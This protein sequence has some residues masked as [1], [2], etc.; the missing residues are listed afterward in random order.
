[1]SIVIQV[2]L[3]SAWTL[4]HAF[5]LCPFPVEAGG[6][7]RGRGKASCLPCC[8]ALRWSPFIVVNRCLHPLLDPMG[9]LS[10]SVRSRGGSNAF[11]R[12]V[13][14]LSFLEGG[15]G[16]LKTSPELTPG[17][18][19]PSTRRKILASGPSYSLFIMLRL[20]SGTRCF[21]TMFQKKLSSCFYYYPLRSLLLWRYLCCTT[22]RWS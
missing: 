5:A 16:G 19:L 13:P 12:F 10:I 8:F 14:A 4:E 6:R 18:A 2:R 9:T 15:S 3:S 17:N 22:D 20:S 1:M 21:V 11:T 7:H